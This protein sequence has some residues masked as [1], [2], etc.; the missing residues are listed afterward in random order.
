MTNLK[1]YNCVEY[2]GHEG[3]N[4]VQFS[5]SASD[6]ET[7]V[8]DWKRSRNTSME[9]SVASGLSNDSRGN[10]CVAKYSSRKSKFTITEDKKNDHR[11]SKDSD[12]TLT[13]GF[14]RENLKEFFA[15]IK[16]KACLS[17]SVSL[18]S[19]PHS[20]E[21]MDFSTLDKIDA[22]REE[23]PNSEQSRT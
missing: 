23:T 4:L 18:P 6:D 2:E 13:A 11:I 20:F 12:N 7:S 1:S 5:P 21:N 19:A 9:G 17:V 22:S 3:E 14:V 10:K 16:K 8:G 15:A